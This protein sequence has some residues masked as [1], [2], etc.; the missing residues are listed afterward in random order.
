MA[1]GG[2]TFISG[3]AH[4]CGASPYVGDICVFAGNYCPKNY[5]PA[6]GRQM[7]ISGN[8]QLY[9]VIG[10]TYGGNQV[11]YFNLPDM[12]GRSPMGAG[13][14]L[15][16]SNV[17]LGERRGIEAWTLTP[18]NLP[19]QVTGLTGVQAISSLIVG[20][21]AT[22]NPPAFAPAG[23]PTY[24]VNATAAAPSSLN[25]LFTAT[26]PSGTTATVPVTT[27]VTSGSITLNG[28]DVPLQTLPPQ[29]GLIHCIATFG[30][31]PTRPN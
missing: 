28:G 6:D 7:P 2:I 20:E 24:M 19:H 16:L 12:R 22:A 10:A 11:S 14:G 26:Q 9:W 25:G 23:Q 13:Q 27:T 29:L 15:G 21:T 18:A 4:A 1:A 3:A 8:E 31:T 5:L 17:T 30:L